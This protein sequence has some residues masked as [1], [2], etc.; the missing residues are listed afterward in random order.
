MTNITIIDKDYFRWHK[1][2]MIYF[3]M[4]SVLCT[5][6]SNYLKKLLQGAFQCC[7]KYDVIELS[8]TYF[9]NSNDKQYV[10]TTDFFLKERKILPFY[11]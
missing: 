6:F 7:N 4:V 1:N 10:K 9:D 5:P 11:I 3:A 8:L 2:L